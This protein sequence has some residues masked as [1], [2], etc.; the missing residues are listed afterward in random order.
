MRKL[1]ANL[2]L[3][4]AVCGLIP[5]GPLHAVGEVTFARRVALLLIVRIAVILAHAEILH[6][7]GWGIA[8]VHR[9]GAG[10]VLC[11]KGARRV[12]G[13]VDR[14]RFSRDGK[15]DHRFRQ[16]KFAFRR[17][18][19][20]VDVGGA[21]RDIECTRIGEA[22]V[23]RGHADHAPRQITWVSAAIEH[24]AKPVQRRIGVGAAHAFVE[25]RNLIVKIIAA[26]VET[27]RC[28]REHSLDELGVYGFCAATFG[29]D[30]ELL[31]QIDQ[32][33]P[34]AVGH[35]YHARFGF[36][37]NCDFLSRRLP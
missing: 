36:R 28:T 13:V 19:P 35:V 32:P 12:I 18:Q 33:P 24:A 27:P 11:D 26:L 23:F 2:C 21:E 37:I 10:F 3:E 34:I 29:G 8:D 5:V 20:L 17:S 9:H 22:D 31:D 30:A 4:A 6:Q 14:V 25:R 15:I 7:L 1:F 16:C